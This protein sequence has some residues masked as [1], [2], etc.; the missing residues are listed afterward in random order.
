MRKCLYSQEI[1]FKKYTF[2]IKKKNNRISITNLKLAVYFY[3]SV[4]SHFKRTYINTYLLNPQF[5]IGTGKQ[6]RTNL[7]NIYWIPYTIC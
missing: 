3:F 5:S 7:T 2:G 6:I 4:N 1:L